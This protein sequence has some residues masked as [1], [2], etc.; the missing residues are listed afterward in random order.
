MPFPASGA[1]GDVADFSR[2]L[3]QVLVLTEQD[4]HIEFAVARHAHHVEP[5]PQVDSLLPLDRNLM[6]G[7]VRQPDGFDPVAQGTGGNGDAR[8][9]HRGQAPR[10]VAVPH[11]RPVRARNAGVEPHAVVDPAVL[12][13]ERVGELARIVVGMMVAERV[14][15]VPVQVLPV[16]ERDGALDV[17]LNGHGGKK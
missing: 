3:R 9:P 1:P 12:G 17:V 13:A 2:N 7:T 11:R 8:P 14:L 16:D 10:P 15:R 6:D 4:R 5:Q